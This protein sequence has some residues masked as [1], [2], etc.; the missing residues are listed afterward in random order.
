MTLT[1]EDLQFFMGQEWIYL[2]Q[3]PGPHTAGFSKTLEAN[4]YADRPIKYF[5]NEQSVTES[6]FTSYQGGDG[7][8]VQL[9]TFPRIK[10]SG[11]Y[12]QIIDPE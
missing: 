7:S 8:Y 1:I 3:H 5:I 11:V 9:G 10:Q 12:A 2:Y 4:G 6:V